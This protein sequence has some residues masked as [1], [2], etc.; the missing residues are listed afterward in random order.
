MIVLLSIMTDGVR[1]AHF[2]KRWVSSI[3]GETSSVCGSLWGTKH[4]ELLDRPVGKQQ[5]ITNEQSTDST[6]C[7]YNKD[8]CMSSRGNAGVGKGLI[9]REGGR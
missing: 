7:T 8:L 3:R 5:V 1:Q 2:G 9:R 6:R 4:I